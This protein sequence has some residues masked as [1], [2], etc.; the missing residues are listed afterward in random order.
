[1]LWRILR[2]SFACGSERRV[3]KTK[4][5][6][7]QFAAVSVTCVLAGADPLWGRRAWAVLCRQHQYCQKVTALR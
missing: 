4:A 1:M 6:A 7:Q 5:L 3:H 2:A